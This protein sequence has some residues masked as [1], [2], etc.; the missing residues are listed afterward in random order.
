VVEASEPP[1][2][3]V[4]DPAQR[5]LTCVPEWRMANIMDKGTSFRE[6]TIKSEARGY[7]R[8]KLHDFNAVSE[9]TPKV[10][11]SCDRE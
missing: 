7:G 10:I 3:L 6:I 5:T 9:A 8:R 2:Y 1:I 11:V 4:E